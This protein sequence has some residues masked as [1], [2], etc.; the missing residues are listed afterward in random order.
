[1]EI[2][3]KKYFLDL[4][5]YINK[6]LNNRENLFEIHSHKINYKYIE[7]SILIKVFKDNKWLKNHVF[8]LSKLVEKNFDSENDDSDSSEEEVIV[9]TKNDFK[10]INILRF[11]RD[12]TIYFFKLSFKNIFIWLKYVYYSN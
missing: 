8:F 5:E 3:Q 7:K 10:I 12:I 2:N 4:I 1:V 6:D 11:I 9:I